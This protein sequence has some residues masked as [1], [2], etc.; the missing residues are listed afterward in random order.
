MRILRQ[1]CEFHLRRGKRRRRPSASWC[2]APRRQ[3]SRRQ[4]SPRRR[5][6]RRQ[7]PA[8]SCAWTQIRGH[9]VRHRPPVLTWFH[10]ATFHE[11]AV[12]MAKIASEGRI[13]TSTLPAARE[14]RCAGQRAGSAPRAW[15]PRRVH[16]RRF[17]DPHRSSCTSLARSTSAFSTGQL[18]LLYH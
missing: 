8:R 3:A 6:P 17:L 7:G 18:S 5:G 14:L 16:N 1:P 13:S 15:P 11:E 4:G 2:L 10:G 9:L 12:F